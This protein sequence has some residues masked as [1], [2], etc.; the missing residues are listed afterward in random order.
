MM[1]KS[2]YVGANLT[3]RLPTTGFV[4]LGK[5]RLLSMSHLFTCARGFMLEYY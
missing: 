5:L 4:T 1:G 3:V 2:A